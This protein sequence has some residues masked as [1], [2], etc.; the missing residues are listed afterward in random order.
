M[1]GFAPVSYPDSTGSLTAERTRSAVTKPPE[2]KSCRWLASDTGGLVVSP[3]GK[4]NPQAAGKRTTV[5]IVKSALAG[6]ADR[7]GELRVA[8]LYSIGEANTRGEDNGKR[9]HGTRRCK[10]WRHVD[11]VNSSNWGG[12]ARFRRRRGMTKHWVDPI[13]QPGT[14]TMTSSWRSPVK[15]RQRISG[16]IRTTSE[17]RGDAV[18]GVGDAR[19]SDDH[20]DSKTRWE[21]RGISLKTTSGTDFRHL[22]AGIEERLG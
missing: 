8:S 10:R 5:S 4:A 3:S 22:V 20:R 19:S 18:Q 15:R 21:R 13:P 7:A 17:S 2:R 14:T 6:I 9:T 12:P 16:G 1:K 11:T